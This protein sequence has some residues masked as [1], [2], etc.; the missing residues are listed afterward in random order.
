M[1]VKLTVKTSVGSRRWEPEARVGE[2]QLEEDMMSFLRW[3]EVAPDKRFGE[4]IDKR[5]IRA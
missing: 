3:E 5:T 4:L 1:T 2:A